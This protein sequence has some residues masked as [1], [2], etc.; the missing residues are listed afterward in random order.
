MVIHLSEIYY[1][2]EMWRK[3]VCFLK[4]KEKILTNFKKRRKKRKE[5][6]CEK[7]KMI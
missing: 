7:N 1:I 4:E 2:E 6:C 3:F 5:S